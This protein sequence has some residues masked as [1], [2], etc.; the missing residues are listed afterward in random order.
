VLLV[1]APTWLRARAFGFS[2]YDFGIYSQAV[3]RLALDPPNPWLSGR[4]LYVFN[5]HFDP[6]LFLTLPFARVFPAP[7]V[8]LITEALCALLALA[9]LAWLARAGR[10]APRTTWLLGGL[11]SLGIGVTQ[12][13]HVV[14]RVRV[15]HLIERLDQLIEEVMLVGRAHE[16]DAVG[17]FVGEESRA[18]AEAERCATGS[19][20]R[21][22]EHC[23]QLIDQVRRHRVLQR[24]A[25]GHDEIELRAVELGDEGLDLLE[26][27]D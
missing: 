4:Q 2:N 5:D 10:I 7:Q 11:M 9:P 15:G 3:A 24:V 1:S 25:L 27:R 8:G 19:D 21:G 12:E 13:D 14:L 16:Q 18:R 17:A 20:L 6:I 23:G 26:V 22:A